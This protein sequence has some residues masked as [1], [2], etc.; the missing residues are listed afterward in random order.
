MLNKEKVL[1]D[2]VNN[3]E[4]DHKKL[5]FTYEKMIRELRRELSKHDENKSKLFLTQS[6][7]NF[8]TKTKITSLIKTGQKSV[9]PRG[10]LI[11]TKS[12]SASN[13]SKG[14]INNK[15]KKIKDSKNHDKDN[16]TN[17]NNYS[18]LSEDSYV[19]ENRVNKRYFYY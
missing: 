4:G 11:L 17:L 12:S 3:H 18:N 14:K 1:E 2:I 15:V 19:T 10:K 13:L 5:V 7:I 9:K 6:L 16:E 8:K